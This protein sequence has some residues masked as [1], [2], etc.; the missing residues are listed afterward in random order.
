MQE[1]LKE[2]SHRMLTEH[3]LEEEEF[4]ARLQKRWYPAFD[5]L[6]ILIVLSEEAERDF[7]P[8]ESEG[9]SD[10]EENIV[11]ALKRIHIR[12]AR[13]AREVFCLLR[14]GFSDGAFA[15]WRTLHDLPLSALFIKKHGGNV[16]QKYMD[17]RRIETYYE[18]K[19]YREHNEELGY[20]KEES[21]GTEDEGQEEDEK[22]DPEKPTS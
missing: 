1:A 18:I 8:R 17:Y 7:N 12:A 20:E 6:R 21:E 11:E 22:Q 19:K 16:A 9:L 4:N 15:R 2:N 3:E 10:E 14:S 5:R 13:C